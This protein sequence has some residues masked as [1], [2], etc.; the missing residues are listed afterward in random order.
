[1]KKLAVITTHP[2]QYY[3]PIFKLLNQR[4]L[5]QLKVFY[6]WG[7]VSI[8]KHDPGFDKQIE[9]DIPLLEGYDYE[10]VINTS[11]QPGSHHFSGIKNP[12]IINQINGYQPDAILVF[13]WAYHAH[14]KVM[15]HFKNKLPVYFR[16]DST[17]LNEKPGLKAYVKT[18]FLKWVYRHID[19]AFYVGTNNK[20]YFLKYGLKEQQLSFAPHAVDN[21]R[22]AKD[23]HTHSLRSVLNIPDK[24]MVVLYCGK[25]ESVKNIGV[26]LSA[27]FNINKPDAHLIIV[28]NGTEEEKLKQQARESNKS[29][30]IH[31]VNFQNQS[32]MP[33]IYHTASIFCLP[34]K[35]ETWGLV[36]NEAMACGKP[37]IV[38][39]RVGCA[40]D[41]VTEINGY[42]FKSG[43]ATDLTHGLEKLTDNRQSLAEMGKASVEIIKNWNF[44]RIADAIEKKLN[45]A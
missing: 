3:A 36:V 27:F 21:E 11:K 18:L 33:S 20:N 37:I 24:A 16:G 25:L 45:E 34:S 42:I 14:L 40:V 22:F 28:G 19:H 13:G 17:L 23:K 41:L 8:K 26:L 29:D 9:W 38:S 1:M 31:W 15:R 44:D 32:A 12:W 6:T 35:N 39:D 5:I 4:G 30:K 10:W 43:D 7:E 2:I